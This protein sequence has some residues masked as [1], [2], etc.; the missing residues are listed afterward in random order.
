MCSV[1][2]HPGDPHPAGSSS[3][4]TVVPPASPP[5][6]FPAAE[7]RGLIEL[8]HRYGDQHGERLYLPPG[9][10][11][12]DVTYLE[13]TPRGFPRHAAVRALRP[14]QAAPNPAAAA[15]S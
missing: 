9:A 1:G 10:I 2:N 14:A 5:S 3:A 4:T 7:R 13:R 6:P 8:T 12:A 15:N 11:Q